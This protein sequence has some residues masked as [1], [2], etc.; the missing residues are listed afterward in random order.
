MKD[1]L[2][3]SARR[4]LHSKTTALGAVAAMT[5][6]LAALAFTL[7]FDALR[8]LTLEIGVR[9]E[10]AWMAPVA[11]DVAQAAAALALVALGTDDE[12]RGARLYCKALAT[13]TVLFSVA[14]NG[15]HAF[16]LAGQRHAQA[17]AGVDVG[18]QPQPAAIAACIAMIVPLLFLAL[19]H[20]FT[21]IVRALAVERGRYHEAVHHAHL[22]AHQEQAAS[23]RHAS[24]VHD[25]AVDAPVGHDVQ[26]P[27]ARVHH[28]AVPVAA[29]PATVQ[30][31]VAESFGEDAP[32]EGVAQAP[33]SFETP[34][35]PYLAPTSAGYRQTVDGL[36]EFLAGCTLRSEEKEV[37][38]ILLDRPQLTYAQVAVELEDT[39]SP[40]TVC[41]R[42]QRFKNAAYAEGFEIPP[43]VPLPLDA[44]TPREEQLVAV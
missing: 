2:V 24:E 35:E 40:S 1:D 31:Q 5:L 36:R 34:L 23:T 29:E 44:V 11:L 13:G 3:Q 43:V 12:F 19:L 8:Q 15:Y 7:S 26:D 4:R 18:Y 32:G 14:G 21:T 39:P 6:V 30:P 42:W 41:R 17:A 22:A 33:T 20:L 37:A 28:D 25:V 10:L 27:G 16:R 38:A 9:P